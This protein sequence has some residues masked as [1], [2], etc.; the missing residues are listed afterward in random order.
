MFETSNNVK[1]RQPVRIAGVQ[2]GEVMNVEPTGPG[3]EQALVTMRIQKE[4]LPSTRT[5]S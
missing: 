3:E 2:V 5:R 4:G 1:K